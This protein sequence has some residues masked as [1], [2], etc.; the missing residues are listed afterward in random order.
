MVS[1]T[2]GRGI[3][4]STEWLSGLNSSMMNWKGSP[5]VIEHR[6]VAWWVIGSILSEL[7]FIF[8]ENIIYE[9]QCFT[10]L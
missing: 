7:L 2:I 1:G 8:L 6:L 4:K 5:L 10:A 9:C 3:D